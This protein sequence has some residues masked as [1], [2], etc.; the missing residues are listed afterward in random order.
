MV[1]TTAAIAAPRSA[2]RLL[3]AS[4][5]RLTRTTVSTGRHAALDVAQ[6]AGTDDGTRRDGRPHSRPATRPGPRTPRPRDMMPGVR[7]RRGARDA[8]ARDPHLEAA[9]GHAA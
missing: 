4:A 8:A 1:P 3:A 9:F 6:M 5:P 2:P 7:S